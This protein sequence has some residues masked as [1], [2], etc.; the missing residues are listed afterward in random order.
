MFYETLMQKKAEANYHSRYLSRKER[1][2]AFNQANQ[3]RAAR[4]EGL[5]SSRN[6]G[7]VAGAVLGGLGGGFVGGSSRGV[8]GALLGGGAGALIGGGLGYGI[9]YLGDESRD[10]RTREAREILK[11]SPKARATLLDH[12]RA[13]HLEEEDAWR[14]AEERLHRQQI[15]DEIRSSR[16]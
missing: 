9:G 14:Q 13:I 3:R 1:N 16:Q 8:K 5:R 10:S 6:A 12:K 4:Q 2:N 11:M 15:L 7:G